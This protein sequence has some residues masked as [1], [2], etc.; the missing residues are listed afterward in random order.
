MIEETRRGG[1]TSV[2]DTALRD[3]AVSVGRLDLPFIRG[4]LTAGAVPPLARAAAL[5]APSR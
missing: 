5:Y 4:Q 2:C 3:E 1:L